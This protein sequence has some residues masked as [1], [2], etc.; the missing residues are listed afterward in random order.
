MEA[1][2]L[3][4]L[5]KA[6]EGIIV[7]LPLGQLATGISIDS[8]TVSKGDLFVAIKG[9]SFDAH[10]YLADVCEK[11][12]AAVI[13][14]EDLFM[15]LK[16]REAIMD[17]TTDKSVALLLVPD[18]RI[19]LGAVASFYL[20]MFSPKVVAVTGSSGKTTTREILKTLLEVRYKVHSSKGNFNND[21]GLPL[22]I[23]GL[24]KEHEILLVELGM[25]H[26]GE[27]KQLAEVCRPDL[28]LITNVGRAHI[29]FF[30]DQ[31]G[32]A[33]AKKE[34]FSYFNDD[35]IAVLN[36]DDNFASFLKSGLSGNVAWFSKLPTGF[37]IKEDRGLKGYLLEHN[38]EQL[39][40]PMGGEHNLYN[41]SAAM[42]A[43]EQ[44]GL[45]E[46]VCFKRIEMIPVVDART[47]IVEGRYTII[48]DS[49]NANP[50]SMKSALGLLKAQSG[51]RRFAVLGDMFELG[52]LSSQLHIELGEW[53]AQQGI[54]DF[55]IAVGKDMGQSA[56]AAIKAG[57][58]KESVFCF[59][60]A[61]AAGL[62]LTKELKENDI[63]LVKGSRGMHLE[64]VIAALE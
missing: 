21:I 60:D 61:K 48:N 29:E 8:R 23:F 55:F 3:A 9:D 64:E 30:K 10:T 57:I 22:T 37:S 39:L 19:G 32:I 1:I 15:A 58:S 33:A 5:Y 36:K 31:Q 53:I 18:S 46:S 54:C 38:N 27:L 13:A 12:A 6:I 63:V 25:N 59:S 45:T 24:E 17:L 51:G 34:V 16:N 14:Q 20:G 35:S 26:A 52:D 11:G 4:Q 44:L 41:L 40:F 28:A 42:A 62:W 49:Y 7:N 2:K 56:K 43:A 47:Q 50:D